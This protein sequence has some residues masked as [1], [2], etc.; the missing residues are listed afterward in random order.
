[1]ADVR[2]HRHHGAFGIFIAE[3]KGSHYLDPV[4]RNEVHSVSDTT[5]KSLSQLVISHPLLG[6]FRDFVVAMHDGVRLV[7]KGGNLIIDPEPLFMP[8]EEPADPEDQGSRGLNYRNERFSHRV[9]NFNDISR[10]FSSKEHGEP[11]TPIFLSY[12]GD[13]VTFRVVFP[14]DRARAHS[15]TIHGHSWLRSPEDLNSSVIAVN[16][17]NSV[18]KS[19]DLYL[20]NGAGGLLNTPGDYMYRSGNIRWDVELGVWGILKVLDK[21]QNTLAPL[22]NKQFI[23]EEDKCGQA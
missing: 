13:P 6:E 19:D 9:K 8:P 20:E 14:A 11:A 17:Q 4:T 7:D 16:G 12:P 1:M 21:P 18:G 22:E 2:N 23:R 15:F 10:V 5:H 3:P